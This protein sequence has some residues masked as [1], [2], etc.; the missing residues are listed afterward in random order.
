MDFGILNYIG[1]TIRWI[2]G[3]IWRTVFHKKR[4]N[5][6]EY[7]YG[8]DNSESWYD[9]AGHEFINRLIAI[10]ILLFLLYLII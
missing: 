8:P 5:Y 4:F 10:I 3:S 7:L 2:Y 9:E 6:N 1:G